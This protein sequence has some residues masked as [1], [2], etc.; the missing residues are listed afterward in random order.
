[1]RDDTVKNAV[2]YAREHEADFYDDL[3]AILRLES[4]GTDPAYNE[5]TRATALMLESYLERIGFD[6]VRLI[7]TVGQPLV[8][9]ELT[10]A[11]DDA[12]TVLIYGHYDVQPADPLELWDTPPFDPT[13]VG[14]Y[15][16]ARGASDDKGQVMIVLRAI[17]AVLKSGGKVPVNV[18]VLLE[19]EEEGGGAGIDDFLAS[20]PDFLSADIALVADSTMASR[21]IPALIYGLRGITYLFVDVNGPGRDLHSGSFGGAVNNPINA[22]AHII[23]RLKS[24]DGRILIP[25]F[26]DQVRAI[27][28][29]ERRILNS[30]SVSEEAILLESGA[31]AL[32]GEPGYSVVERTSIRP[33]L[34]VNGIVGGFIGEGQKT[35]L[36]ASAHAKISMRLV[37]DQDPFEVFRMAESYIMGIAPESVTVKVTL[38]HTGEA[39]TVLPDIPAICAAS[40]ALERVFG[41]KPELRKEGGSIPVVATLQKRL[42][43]DAVLMGFGQS[44]DNIHSPNERF[45]IPNFIRGIESVVEF[46]V[47]L[48]GAQRGC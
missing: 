19:G 45:Y 47:R 12:P 6:S 9:G 36:P 37:P 44:D 16:Y 26:Y 30:S 20:E 3:F 2:E 17:E 40:A 41:S 33:T 13:I 42:G 43:I 5:A 1:M 25:S 11:G 32:W 38:A 8:Y 23:T 18:K 28:E 29:K 22:L 46:L 39:C 24:E 34:D 15:L 4:I 14:D 35:V 7:E 27:S 21:D 31:P 10:A 48:P